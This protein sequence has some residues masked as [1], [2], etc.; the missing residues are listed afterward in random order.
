MAA[1]MPVRAGIFMSLVW[2]CEGLAP[3]SGT[4]VSLVCKAAG[5]IEVK[6]TGHSHPGKAV[7]H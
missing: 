3:F 6:K 7:R 2:L 1:A 4:R 5:W